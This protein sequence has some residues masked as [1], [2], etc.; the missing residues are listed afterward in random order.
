MRRQI[1]ACLHK[2]A[3]SFALLR[4]FDFTQEKIMQKQD[5]WLKM[6]SYSVATICALALIAVVPRSSSANTIYVTTSEDKVSDVS[7][8]DRGCSLKEA[9]FAAKFRNHIAIQSFLPFS[10]TITS[11]VLVSADT[12]CVPGSGDDLI[13][14]PSNATLNMSQITV[15]E[16]NFLGPTATPMIFSKVTIQANGATL[17]WTSGGHARAFAVGKGGS[18]TIQNAYIRGFSTQGGKGGYGAGGGGLGAGGAIY[19]TE[20][21]DATILNSTFDSNSA[22]GGN[23]AGGGGINGGGGGGGGLGG[24][25]AS[26]SYTT[27]TASQFQVAGG[28]GGSSSNAS[29]SVGGGT[30]A[31]RFNCGG[32]FD[33]NDASCP[34]GGGGGAEE[35]SVFDLTDFGGNGG[36]GGGGGGGAAAGHGGTGGFGGGGGGAFP[37]ANPDFGFSSQGG[38]GG[39]GGGSGNGLQVITGGSGTPGPFG[40]KAHGHN[41]GG[42][43]ALGGA[44]FVHGGTVVIQNSTF[45]NN[46]VFR[47]AGGTDGDDHGDSGDDAGAAIFCV[48]CHLTVQNATISGNI[49]TTADGGIKVYQTAADKPVSF[50]LEN[51][52]IWANGNSGPDG[53][54]SGTPR[55]CSIVAS[56]VAGSFSGNLIENNDNCPGVVTQ[57]NPFLGPLELNGGV[58][59]TMAIPRTSAAWNLGSS[60]SLS[61]D[62]RGT[63]RP[64]EGGYDIG[65]FELCDPVHN[66]NCFLSGIAQTEPLN[67]VVSPPQG[68]ST[69]PAPGVTT[70]GTNSVLVVQASPAPG[71][72]FQGWLGN[73]AIPT[74]EVTTVVMSQAETITANFV[75]C[76]CAVDVSASITISRGGYALNPGTGRFV[77]TDTL[78]NNSASTITGPISLVI[79]GLSGNATLFNLTGLTDSFFPPV[80]LPYINTAAASLAPGQS[81]S[82]TLQFANPS[83][84]GITYAN[85]ILAGPGA[86]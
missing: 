44:I 56:A 83:K 18:L 47:G 70:A 49:S 67:I 22:L 20:G 11:L 85:R 31:L 42:G 40:G 86:R 73:V 66:L 12:S 26:Y 21:G 79:E 76:G 80:G 10:N 81:V 53:T 39:F 7:L 1:G 78:T 50:I 14:L 61:T 9:L 3:Y 2:S 17:N 55:E 29:A 72:A 75:P 25:G 34:G 36:Y 37:P 74:S 30:V 64:Q 48:D 6:R 35:G 28:G 65:A 45:F 19:V 84:A 13:I 77:Q 63:P 57:G 54:H 16:D 38:D 62:Q 24:N 32:G 8:G 82:V 59:P 52:I 69:I 43:G 71:Y 58:T 4:E 15:D 60:T 5:L 23:G 41:G 33:S 51:T 68:G 27:D 46:R